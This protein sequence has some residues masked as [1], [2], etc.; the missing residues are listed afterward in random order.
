MFADSHASVDELPYITGTLLNLSFPRLV[1]PDDKSSGISLD[2]SVAQENGSRLVIL[3]AVS[4]HLDFK[5]DESRETIGVP[6]V[7]KQNNRGVRTV[8]STIAYDLNTSL[9]RYCIS[10][11]G[12]RTSGLSEVLY[13]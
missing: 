8:S 1:A 9:N 4:E 10:C 7:D 12:V 6:N 13:F 11:T 5:K 3:P 2:F